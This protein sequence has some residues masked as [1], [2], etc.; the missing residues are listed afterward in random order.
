MLKLVSSW[1]DYLTIESV[2]IDLE[3]F[4]S[5]AKRSIINVEDVKVFY[6]LCL[7]LT[8]AMLSKERR[9]GV[10]FGRERVNCRAM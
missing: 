6:E 5:H 2:A 8:I 3:S 7:E 4:A 1:S 9:I 10:V